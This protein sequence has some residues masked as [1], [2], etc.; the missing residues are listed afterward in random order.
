MAAWRRILGVLRRSPE[1][2]DPL[3]DG[4]L[5]ARFAASR[6]QAAFELLVWRHAA[7]VFGVCRRALRD[8]HLAEDAFQAA[9]LV[10]AR[11]AGAVRGTNVAGWLFRI[12]RRVAV[13]TAKRLTVVQQI[14]VEPIATALPDR[15]EQDELRTLLDDEIAR[16]PERFRLPVLLCY[17]GGLSTEDAARQLGVPRGTILS[18]LSTARERLSSR[19]TRR[20]V[21]VPAVAVA[22][23]NLVSTTV[24]AAGAFAARL[25]P[26]TT[27]SALVA[28]GVLRT[29]K[30]TKVVPLAAL[31]VVTG[32][33]SGYGLR[34]GPG[35]TP[36]V[37]L[38]PEKAA[39]A[40]QPPKA[41]DKQQEIL[42]ERQAQLEKA[43]NMAERLR[44]Q[45]EADERNIANMRRA[46]AQEGDAR[47][48]ARLDRQLALLETEI[49][50]GEKEL[51]GLQVRR[52]LMRQRLD[53]DRVRV[54]EPNLFE[55]DKDKR[56]EEL[57]LAIAEA[58]KKLDALKSVGAA[59]PTTVTLN[60]LIADKK[61]QLNAIRATVMLEFMS[62]ARA[63]VRSTL[64]TA[65][66]ETEDALSMAERVLE[67][68]KRTRDEIEKRLAQRDGPAAVNTDSLV[69]AIKPKKE[70]LAR[71]NAQIA[72][73]ELGGA[74]PPVEPTV[75]GVEAKLDVLIREVEAL[76]KDVRELKKR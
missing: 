3:P 19:L 4:E 24:S 74:L 64:R 29:M 30:L 70:L 52:D 20:G 28:E 58:E 40:P 7:M 22:T 43:L 76:R 23:P 54:P 57:V 72:Q 73:L 65:L 71:L 36:V 37:A 61:T 46:I 41:E 21:T 44:A 18:R 31:V 34:P 16:L 13:R 27:R 51:V 6:D 55:I 69:E 60:K 25:I 45:I 38:Q 56:V 32:L 14:T 39:A 12:A 66:D 59:A 9:F 53:G 1:T 26:L 49:F 42:R 67:H 15:L 48:T 8:E 35:V 2:G 10:L 17:L 33:A 47:G 5:L 11:K 75:S 50:A 63:E 62:R 68:R